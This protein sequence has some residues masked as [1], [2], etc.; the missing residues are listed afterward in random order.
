MPP[1]LGQE[2]IDLGLVSTAG[3][4]YEPA[5]VLGPQLPI[6]KMRS[7]GSFPV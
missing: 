5:A 4:W 1:L 3:F 2:A 6:Y 7:P